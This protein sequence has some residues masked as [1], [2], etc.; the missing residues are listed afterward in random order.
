MNVDSSKVHRL[1]YPQVPL[2]LAASLRGRT[3]AMPVVSY[4][5]LSDSPPLVGVA[6]SPFAFTYKLCAK[7]GAFTLSVLDRSSLRAVEEL[8]KVSG[9]KVKDKLAAVGLSHSPGSRVSSPVLGKSV[10]TIECT[11]VSK[12]KVGDHVLLIGRVESCIA[13][14]DFADFW[15]FRKYKPILYAGWRDGMTI[16]RAP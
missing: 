12:R 13:N 1:F 6:C 10:A 11:V 3:S 4:A 15:T 7:S 9:A 8:A 16:F 2:V 5:S 14:D